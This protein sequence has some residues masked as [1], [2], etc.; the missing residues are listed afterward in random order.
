MTITFYETGMRTWWQHFSSKPVLRWMQG[1]DPTHHWW[2]STGWAALPLLVLLITMVG[3]KWKAHLS[4]LLSLSVAL[5][6][7]TVVFHMPVSL[8]GLAAVY[9]AGYGLFPIFW[10]IF[11]VIF[12]YQLTVKANRFDLLQGCLIDV[13][14]DSRLQLL[15]IAFCLGAFFEGAAG[16]DGDFGIFFYLLSGTYA[17]SSGLMRSFF[18]MAQVVIQ[19][20][21]SDLSLRLGPDLVF[22]DNLND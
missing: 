17:I 3:F 12:L 1:Y 21:V 16:F 20:I 2:L 18:G 5:V 13:T 11:P 6:I 19:S 10:I 15:L 14:E 4:A 22:C 9:G 8:A 7:A